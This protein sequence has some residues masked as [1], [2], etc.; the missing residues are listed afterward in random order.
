MTIRRTG[1]AKMRAATQ[2]AI[3]PYRRIYLPRFFFAR[4]CFCRRSSATLSSAVLPRQSC[5]FASSLSL[6]RPHR[7]G[8]W[9]FKYSLYASSNFLL[10]STSPKLFDRTLIPPGD[11]THRRLQKLRYFF[12]GHIRNDLQIDDL[13][14]LFIQIRK[15]FRQ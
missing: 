13:P 4:R 5:C 1:T 6:I 9:L 11:R 2:A 8:A 3:A 10:I 12:K 7:S 14:L 15:G